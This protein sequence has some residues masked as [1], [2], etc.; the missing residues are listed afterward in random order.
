MT[1]TRVCT[2]M[3][4]NE[5]N[6][7]KSGFG[8][9]IALKQNIDILIKNIIRDWDFTILVT[10][11]GEVRVGKS[12]LAMQIACYIYYQMQVV[13]GK[14]TIFDLK[15]NFAF[16]GDELTKKGH[17]LGKNYPYS[18]L[19]FDEAGADLEGRKVVTTTT[20]E[21]L[22]YFRECG[23]Y[24]LFNILVIPEYFDLP[25]GVALSRSMFLVDVR[26]ICDP[27][28]GIFKRGILRFFNRKKK[29]WLYL[30][31]KKDLNYNASTYNFHGW[32][33]D[34][35]PIDKEEY[36]ELK[37][38]AMI[39]RE[40]KKVDKKTQ[41]RDIVMS[42]CVTNL[43]FKQSHLVDLFKKNDCPLSAGSISTIITK[44]D[45]KNKEIPK[46]MG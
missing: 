15:H 31:G 8:M 30:K 23:Q 44:N 1:T 25:K 41:Q 6:P 19:I 38:Q 34:F 33:T 7:L 32:F 24:N 43:G 17:Y 13:H 16:K 2:E 14:K 29:K 35:Y 28:T 10:G 22:D 37:L 27:K 11:G 42:L 3:F 9:E 12:V 20:K 21:V 26:Y 45:N 5:K 40:E 4:P 18:P 36:K 39:K 46:E